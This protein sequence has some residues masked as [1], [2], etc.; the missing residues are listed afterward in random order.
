[1]KG[2]D[3]SKTNIRDAFASFI[4]SHLFCFVSIFCVDSIDLNGNGEGTELCELQLRI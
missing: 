2:Q 4:L 1:L 3:L